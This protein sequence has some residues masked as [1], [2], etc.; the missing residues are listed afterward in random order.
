MTIAWECAPW[1]D[2]T[3][4]FIWGAVVGLLVGWALGRWNRKGG[5]I[6]IERTFDPSNIDP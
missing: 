1:V 4:G 3:T 2:Y 6:R 5:A